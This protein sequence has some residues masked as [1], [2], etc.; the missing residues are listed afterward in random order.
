[1]DLRKQKS[2]T[3]P[4]ETEAKEKEKL[5]PKKQDLSSQNQSMVQI[6]ESLKTKLDRAEQ[7]EDLLWKELSDKKEKL[8]F[9][10]AGYQ[11][12]ENIW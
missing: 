7:L 11:S 1:M 4:P 12:S 6:I 2:D 5:L 3:D 8:C 9:P 10:L